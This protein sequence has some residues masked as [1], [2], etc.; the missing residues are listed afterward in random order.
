MA[1]RYN[2]REYS[3][4]HLIYGETRRVS[5]RGNITY[6]ARLAA[7]LY[8][9]RYANRNATSYEV[10]LRVVNAYRNGRMPGPAKA[11][12]RPRTIDDNVNTNLK[13]ICGREYLMVK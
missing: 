13:L 7:R 3:D 9:E 10:I 2:Y 11:E 1:N 4:M 8:N 6:N 5:N 12:G